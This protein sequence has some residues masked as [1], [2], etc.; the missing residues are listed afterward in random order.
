VKELWAAR[1]IEASAR[2]G[3]EEA[4]GWRRD[5]FYC[6]LRRDSFGGD[7]FQSYRVVI[8][9][10]W[11]VEAVRATPQLLSEIQTERAHQADRIEHLRFL[12]LLKE[13]EI[14]LNDAGVMSFQLWH[15]PEIVR[16]TDSLGLEQIADQKRNYSGA[17]KARSED[18]EQI[19]LE[20]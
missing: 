12:S 4:E 11:I 9:P 2:R 6:F 8:F 16:D 1:E 15:K 13:D 10:R 7:A 14:S 3:R 19:T 20:K 5:E 18:K 17:P